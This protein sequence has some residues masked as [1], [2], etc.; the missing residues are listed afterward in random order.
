MAF[1]LAPGRPLREAL[2]QAAIAECERALEHL[3]RGESADIHE[4][5]K[6]IKRLRAWLRLLKP[7]L[8]DRYG[9][10]DRLLRDAGRA[11]AGRRDRDVARAT[12][13]SLR[14]GRLLSAAQYAALLPQLDALAPTDTPRAEADTDATHLLRAAAV[15]L[16]SL[17]LPEMDVH[18]LTEALARNR[19]RC[20]RR[21][22]DARARPTAEALHGWRKSVKH[23]ATQSAL[24][25][26]LLPDA[27][28]DVT[29]LKD[30]GETLGLHHD[31]HQLGLQLHADELPDTGL[32]RLRLHDALRTR[33]RQLEQRALRQGKRLFN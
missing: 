1:A 27:A 19:R 25:A 5:R 29:A 11:L 18:S 13:R 32:L 7:A 23:L 3:Q 8:G 6:S 31:H 30:L 21:W 16:R 4:T 28:G 22:R 26:P 2:R 14:R 9:T 20:R 24:L 17:E 15:Y 12:L 10:L 33:L